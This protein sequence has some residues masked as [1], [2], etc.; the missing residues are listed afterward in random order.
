MVRVSLSVPPSLVGGGEPAC[1][2]SRTVSVV[3]T[4]AY[5]SLSFLCVLV[6]DAITEPGFSAPSGKCVARYEYLMLADLRG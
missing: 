4:V 6:D 3:S 2:C 5:H 1:H